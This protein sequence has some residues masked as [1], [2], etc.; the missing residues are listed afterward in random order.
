[1]TPI[2]IT[3][4]SLV[5]LV[6]IASRFLGGSWLSPMAFFSGVW[7]IFL[8]APLVLAPHFYLSVSA[9]LIITAAVIAWFLG[10]LVSSSVPLPKV[11]AFSSGSKK[12]RERVC[13]RSAV[14]FCLIAST[15]A[16][17]YLTLLPITNLVSGVAA[18]HD[19]GLLDGVENI[20]R[21]S[22]SNRYQQVSVPG[23]L[24]NLMLM[25][26]Y[27]ACVFAGSMFGCKRDRGLNKYLWAL[28]VALPML[29]CMGH[30]VVQNTKAT[31][32][33]AL[34]LYGSGYALVHA[35]STGLLRRFLR[36]SNL[37]MAG[38][39]IILAG[40]LF[41]WMQQTRYSENPLSASEAYDLFLVYA[42]GYLGGFSYWIDHQYSESEA[43]AGAQTFALIFKFFDL[44]TS[45]RLPKQEPK[46]LYGDLETNVNTAFSDLMLDF[47]FVGL[48]FFMFCCAFIVS[49]SYRLFLRGSLLPVAILALFYASSLWGFTTSIA[50]YTTRVG[51]IVLFQL[52]IMKFPSL[53]R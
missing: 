20:A 34:V 18:A 10:S 8:S 12:V 24:H 3:C 47:G 53:G 42:V 44:T 32:L 43:T 48:L 29:A 51:G 31:I 38:V 27:T 26:A 46:L 40:S 17:I 11:R 39:L 5:V 52:L 41:L 9:V 14:S 7:L 49:I 35:G 28:G 36:F 4:V 37:M 13:S 22:A 19:Q 33:Y 21:E 6:A 45:V 50:K 23:L 16:L 15:L 30:G 2:L 1:M 25:V